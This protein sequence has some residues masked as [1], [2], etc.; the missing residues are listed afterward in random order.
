M[1]F[2]LKYIE[3]F[4]TFVKNQLVRFVL[5]N[6]LN[7]LDSIGL[8][9]TPPS[10]LDVLIPLGYL[11]ACVLSSF[12][13]IRLFVTQ[14][15]VGCQVL[16]PWD[17]PGK[18]TGVGCH[19]LLQGIFPTQGSNWHTSA[20]AGGFFTTEPPGN[21]INFIH[22]INSIYVNPNLP[23]LPTPVFLFDIHMFVLYV[24][25]STSTLWLTLSVPFF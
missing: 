3:W 24:C 22:S 23:A 1:Y 16:C 8:V 12:S 15:T 9:P 2:F 20:L 11:C 21:P 7:V 10:T 5:G 17:S 6:F 14:W 19:L 4:W 18:N 25:V 13:H